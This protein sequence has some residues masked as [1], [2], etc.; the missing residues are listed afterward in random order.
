MVLQLPSSPTLTLAD[1]VMINSYGLNMVSWFVTIPVMI[2][3]KSRLVDKR[4]PKEIALY[5]RWAG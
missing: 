3:Q 1:W 5:F 4:Y 2:M